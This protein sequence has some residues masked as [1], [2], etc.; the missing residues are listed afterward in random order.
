MKERV[1]CM[2]ERT[3][4]GAMDGAG[5]GVG[6]IGRPERWVEREAGGDGVVRGP[7]AAD[8][9]C[10]EHLLAGGDRTKGFYLAFRDVSNS[11]S[12]KRA[13]HM[14][15][16]MPNLTSSLLQI[17]HLVRG[18]SFGHDRVWRTYRVHDFVVPQM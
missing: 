17:L 1:G 4:K 13:R 15:Y 14:V 11:T 5:W 10:R 6:R 16:I 2:G 7:R 18:E 9:A 8:A 3:R 12:L